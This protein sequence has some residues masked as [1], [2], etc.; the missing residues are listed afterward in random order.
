[1]VLI[2]PLCIGLHRVFSRLVLLRTPPLLLLRPSI[3]LL[4]LSV[5]MVLQ[6]SL[7]RL[8]PHTVF[9]IPSPRLLPLT[10]PFVVCVTV[11]IVTLVPLW[12]VPV[13]SRLFLICGTLFPAMSMVSFI[14]FLTLLTRCS[15]F[16]LSCIVIH[17]SSLDVISSL[18]TLMRC[19]FLGLVSYLATMIFRFTLSCILLGRVRRL[20]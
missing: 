20:L 2:C 8:S 5:L 19:F 1:M 10:A 13:L 14:G 7:S 16:F 12:R 9:S 15:V 18:T 4:C 17:L 11:S 3:R 6:R